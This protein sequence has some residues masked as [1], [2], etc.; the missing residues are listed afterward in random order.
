MGDVGTLSLYL[1]YIPQFLIR[2]RHL[3]GQILNAVFLLATRLLRSLDRHGQT[4]TKD[5]IR[6]WTHQQI[7]CRRP[8]I[9][10]NQCL[11]TSALSTEMPTPF[12]VQVRYP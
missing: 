1:Q 7:N 6:W 11:S 4:R 8:L 5:L 3:G 10:M 2:I 12:G 9:R